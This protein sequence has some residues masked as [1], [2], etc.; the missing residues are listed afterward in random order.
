M[1]EYQFINTINSKYF[2]DKLN[3]AVKDEWIPLLE[4][5][6]IHKWEKDIFYSIILVRKIKK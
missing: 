4:T 5:H 1:K 3:I 6:K 2:E